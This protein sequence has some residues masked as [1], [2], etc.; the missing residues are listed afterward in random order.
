MKDRLPQFVKMNSVREENPPPRAVGCPGYRRCL[1]EAAYKNYCLDCSQCASVEAVADGPSLK[2]PPR[3]P[4]ATAL[5]A[6]STV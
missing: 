1:N 5:P 4:S 2:R 3:S 6:A